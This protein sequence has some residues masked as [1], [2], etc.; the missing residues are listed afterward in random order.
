MVEGELNFTQAVSD[1]RRKLQS[2]SESPCRRP[3]Q[4]PTKSPRKSGGL[5]AVQQVAAQGVTAT[6]LSN[7][8]ER[9]L[10]TATLPVIQGE[11]YFFVP[12]LKECA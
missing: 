1:V 10:S 11:V 9:F 5:Q 8:V 3:G 2:L 7:H 6:A 4:V 12:T